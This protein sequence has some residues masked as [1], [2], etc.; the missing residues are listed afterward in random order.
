[1][2]VTKNIV[3][4]L[5]PV[6]LAGE[7]S[8]DTRAAVEAFLAQDAGLRAIVATA[9]LDRPPAIELP[10]RLEMRSLQRTRILLGR[11]NFWLGFALLFSFAPVI[12]QPL[13][14]ADLVLLA[15]WGGWAVFVATCRQLQATGLEAPRRWLPR[16]LWAAV[17]SLLGSAAGSL[18]ERQTGWRDAIYFLPPLTFG[19]ALW[20]G[21]RLQQIHT[22]NELDRPAT[23]F[24]K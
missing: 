21:E 10:A 8:A 4:D 5:L 3:Q 24:G 18:I 22:P 14:L 12:L 19:L 7:A 13:W 9:A 23:L 16:M 2:Q 11:K 6:Y 1:M 20:L 17:G 15:G